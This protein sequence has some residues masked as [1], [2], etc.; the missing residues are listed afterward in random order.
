MPRLWSE[1][2]KTEGW[3]KAAFRVLM[4]LLCMGFTA[5]VVAR[6]GAADRATDFGA[7]YYPA[8]CA[9]EHKDAYDPEVVLQRFEADGWKLPPQRGSAKT[10]VWLI[11]AAPIY[12]PTTLFVVA[13]LTMLRWPVAVAVWTRLMEGLLALAALL[14][15]D[16]A[17]DAPLLAGGMTCFMLLNCFI[18]LVV[19]NPAG[20][21]IPLCVAAAWCFVKQRWE[22]AGVVML[23][24][25]LVMKPQDAGLVWLYFLLAGG[26]GRKRAL[27]TLAVVGVLAGC[28]A[29]WIAPSSPHWPSELR[30][31]LTLLSVRGGLADPGP[32]GA[33]S[34]NFSE[35]V[36]LQN[37]VSDFKD[38]PRVYNPVSY[39]IGGGL[40][41]VWMVAV[42]RKRAAPDG[43]LLALAAISILTLLPVYHRPYDA[44]LLLLTIPACALV[45]RAGGARRWAALGITAAA[46]FVTSDLPIIF[47]SMATQKLQISTSTLAGKLTLLALQPAPV[48]LLAAGCFYLWLYIRY[49]PSEPGPSRLHAAKTIAAAA[50]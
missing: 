33:T 30:S 8:R 38:D 49:Q 6:I 19:G 43:Q 22:A 3:T 41:L 28:A 34:K 4:V 7:V 17:A 9:S 12:P 32:T 44:K 42:L 27:Q 24:L 46:I 21:V 13:P 48:V 35:V 14:A 39:A 25:A 26:A 1:T 10:S 31:N 15:W 16:L 47:W 20:I 5:R 11:V 37:A 36:S 45:W 23:G 40:I 50:G 18:M 29:I 2:M